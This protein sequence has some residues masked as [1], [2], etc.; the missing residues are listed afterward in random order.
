MPYPF[1][2]LQNVRVSASAQ[3][4]ETFIR[5]ALGQHAFIVEKANLDETNKRFHLHFWQRDVVLDRYLD[6]GEKGKIYW[7]GTEIIEWSN[8]TGEWL[9]SWANEVHHIRVIVWIALFVKLPA[10]ETINEQA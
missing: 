2:L 5:H 9:K 4:V 10:V 6:G 7:G 1:N 8:T 3:D